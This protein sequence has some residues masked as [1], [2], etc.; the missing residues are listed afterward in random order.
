MVSVFLVVVG[1]SLNLTLTGLLAYPLSVRELPG[2]KAF[3]LFLVYTMMFSGGIVPTFFVVRMAGIMDTVWAM[4]VPG[5]VYASNV[6]IV[7]IFTEQLP[8]ELYESARMDR[9]GEFRILWRIALPLSLPVLATV[10]L[11][12]GVG[13]WDQFFEAPLYVTDPV[14]KPL[15]LLVRE[16]TLDANRVDA[17]IERVVPILSLCMAAA[18]SACVPVLVVYPLP[19]A[20][21]R[22]R[23]GSRRG[24]GLMPAFAEGGQEVGKAASAA[25]VEIEYLGE[26]PQNMPADADNF[27]VQGFNK[28]LGISYKHTG[29]ADGGDM[30]RNLGLR[31]ASGNPPDLFRVGTRAQVAQLKNDGALPDLTPYEGSLVNWK[32]LVG[33]EALIERSKFDGKLYT[34]IAPSSVNYD[35][36]YIRKDLDCLPVKFAYTAKD[37][38]ACMKYPFLPAYDKVVGNF[39]ESI[40]KADIDR[41]I[42]DSVIGFIYGAKPLSEY[43]A[44]VK[45]LETKY[46]YKAYM[47]FVAKEMKVQL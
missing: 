34:L 11:F 35:G 28:K 15:Q 8:L 23:T 14:L 21:L 3:V 43:D 26:R 7:K 19:P 20:L 40:P 18:V 16:M 29:F 10:G 2:R 12:Y 47:E 32:K 6:I 31:I 41:Y 13:H 37:V 4:I 42:N 17:N 24:E 1:T 39:P 36:L 22:E 46:G 38:D 45:E 44:F 30:I 27:V 9:A 5:L 25:P 33:D